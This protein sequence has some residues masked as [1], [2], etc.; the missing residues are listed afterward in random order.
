MNTQSIQQY[1]PF[2]YEQT[3][4]QHRKMWRWIAES[5]KTKRS[6]T[7]KK[8]YLQEVAEKPF[9]INDCYLELDC[10]LCN[11][12]RGCR[13]F[14]MHNDMNN[15]M[16]N[17]ERCQNCPA[18]WPHHDRCYDKYED[19]TDPGLYDEWEFAVEQNEWEDAAK[20]AKI[21]AELPMK[22]DDHRYLYAVLPQIPSPWRDAS[23]T[24]HDWGEHAISCLKLYDWKD[25]N[26]WFKTYDGSKKYMLAFRFPRTKS[27]QTKQFLHGTGLYSETWLNIY[28]LD[29]NQK[30]KEL[31]PQFLTENMGAWT[32]RNDLLYLTDTERNQILE[33][34]RENRY[35]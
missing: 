18:I 1:I 9:G 11:Y 25:A 27:F 2:W 26:A 34:E 16:N 10:F 8:E 32:V 30:I 24:I 15:D 17:D 21:I 31:E 22:D 4:E 5:T 7:T 3:I 19:S 20:Y 12:D 14:P 6:C 29:S 35:D 13:L 33:K 28:K 23:G